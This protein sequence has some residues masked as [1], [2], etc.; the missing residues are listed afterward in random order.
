MIRAGKWSPAVFAV[1]SLV[2]AWEYQGRRGDGVALVERASL[3][4]ALWEGG[5]GWSPLGRDTHNFVLT[6]CLLALALGA[7]GVVY[8]LGV[9][10]RRP[11]PQGVS[12]NGTP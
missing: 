7:G 4:R 11:D 8:W 9:R 6:A 10:R 1:G 2:P 12:L 3:W 5:D